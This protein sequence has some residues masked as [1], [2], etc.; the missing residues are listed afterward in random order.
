MSGPSRSTARAARAAVL[1][2]AALAVAATWLSRPATLRSEDLPSSHTADRANG[3]R[4]FY[5]GGCAACHG[6]RLEGGVE[7]QTAFGTFRAPN[8][9]PDREAGIGSWSA[10]DFVNAV[11]RGVSPDGR[12]YYPSFPYTSYLRMRVEDVFDLKAYLD[13][14]DPV[15][16]RAPGHDIGLPWNIRRGIGLWKR[17]YLHADPIV[18]LPVPDPVLE[19]GRYLVEAVGH[20]AECHTPRDR[21][22]GPRLEHWLAGGPSPDGEG[23]VPNITPHDDGLAD[24][25]RKDIVRY[26]KSGFTPDYDTVGGSMAEVQEN[27]A[28]LPEEDL[29]AMAAYLKS[30]PPQPDPRD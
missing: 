23:R 18:P 26:L 13:T 2:L 15:A 27:L 17:L 22:G 1:L 7:I 11:T 24:W 25:S 5:A 16:E 28:Q 4:L 12:H 14:F 3:E 19:R 20:C 10:L 30:A 6:A 29:Q 21:L 8:I 9:S